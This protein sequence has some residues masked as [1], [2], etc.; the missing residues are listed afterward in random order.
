MLLAT[1]SHFGLTG[2]RRHWHLEE[3]P[4]ARGEIRT[5]GDFRLALTR[6]VQSTSYAT[7]AYKFYDNRIRKYTS[8]TNRPSSYT[9]HSRILLTYTHGRLSN[10]GSIHASPMA[11]PLHLAASLSTSLPRPKSISGKFH[12]ASALPSCI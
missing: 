11:F 8:S 4:G 3:M 1:L 9:D 6:R 2:V 7:P 10:G 12:R 5:H